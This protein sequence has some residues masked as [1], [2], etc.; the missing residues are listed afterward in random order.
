MGL[1]DTGPGIGSSGL[2]QRPGLLGGVGLQASPL[3]HPRAVWGVDFT[4]NLSLVG[5]QLLPY[6]D[7]YS[8][9]RNVDLSA[10]YDTISSPAMPTA[11]QGRGAELLGTA[12]WTMAGPWVESPTNVLTATASGTEGDHARYEGL[13]TVDGGTYELTYTVDISAGRIRPVAYGS[14]S[15]GLGSARTVSGTYTEQ[16]QLTSAGGTFT[17]ALIFQPSPASPA[18]SCVVSNISLKRVEPFPGWEAAGM[19]AAG[20]F[21]AIFRPTEENDNS[22]LE[23]ASG[24]TN[25]RF[26][27]YHNDVPA[28]VQYQVFRLDGGLDVNMG[29]NN[30]PVLN[31]INAIAGRFSTNDF[32]YCLNGGEVKNDTSGAIP[33]GLSDL[34]VG[35]AGG[36]PH[37]NGGLVAL[38]F[39]YGYLDNSDV[40]ALSRA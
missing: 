1:T 35:W 23:V 30:Y 2:S 7:G 20:W 10:A 15:F 8:P 36:L 6:A 39:G 13:S 5:G 37:L 26:R 27:I 40:I 29:T 22:I 24:T 33:I 11:V 16:I 38:A 3:F 28:V 19:D 9:A 17:N 25:A 32:A 31:S 18:L 14:G 12:G 34:R 4:R 21:Q